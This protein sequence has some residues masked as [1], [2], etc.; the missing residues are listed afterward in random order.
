MGIG[1]STVADVTCR[2]VEHIDDD[3][4]AAALDRPARVNS[5]ARVLDAWLGHAVGA[6]T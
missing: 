1:V 2:L 4:D 3:A 5:S 6:V